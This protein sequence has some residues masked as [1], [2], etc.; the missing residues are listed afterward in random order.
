MVRWAEAKERRDQL[1][2]FAERLDDALPPDH[3]VR[4]LD[5]VLGKLDWSVWEGKYSSRVGQPPIHPRILASVLLYGLLTRLR[6]SRSLEEAILVRLDFRWL[7]SG[8]TIDHT[9]L[10]EFRRRHPQE[11][12]N[13]FVQVCLV[14]RELGLLTLQ[15]LGFDGTRVRANNRRS[16]SRTAEQLRQERQELAAKFQEL[17]QQVDAEEARDEELF[18]THSPHRLPAELRD[19]KQRLDKLDAILSELDRLG[20]E[21]PQRIPITDLDARIMKNKEGGFAPNFTPLATVDIDSGLIVAADVLSVINEDANL[22]P[23]IEEVQQRFGLTSP[24]R[25]LTDGLNGTGANLAGCEA[26]GIDL[27][28]PCKIPDPAKNPALREEPHQPVAEADWQRLPTNVVRRGKKPGTQLHKDAFVYDEKRDIYWCPQGKSLPHAKT[29]SEANRT[30]RRIR[31]RYQASAT[32]CA[33]CPLRALCLQAKGTPRQIN[34]EQYETHHER[35]AQKMAQPP[36]QAE[37]ALRR[38]AGER[39]FA[40][41]KH[42]FGLRQFLLRG[43]DRVRT[44]W[45]WAATAFNLHRLMSC[46]RSRA[47]PSLAPAV[48]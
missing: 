10:S 39:P 27:Y 24:P 26:R 29:T 5:E 4:M 17:Q 32:D 46:L 23:A 20:K 36:S 31:K 16:G 43:R 14:A 21:S 9:T 2:L 25:V 42:Y 7:V 11:L 1:V 47:G 3:T 12:Q 34:R 33:A 19:P 6:S 30:G 15:R 45:R 18:E 35:H 44:E 38:H 40:M 41:I 8:R 37:Y 48:P 22:I 13:L 28:S